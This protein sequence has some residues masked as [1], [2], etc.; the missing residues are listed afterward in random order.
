MLHRVDYGKELRHAPVVPQASERHGRPDGRMRVL[1]PIFSDSRGVPFDVSEISSLVG[2]QS[3]PRGCGLDGGAALHRKFQPRP[4]NSANPEDTEKTIVQIT[5]ET[6][7]VFTRELL[8]R[9]R[10]LVWGT[11]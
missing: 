5:R 4:S 8:E 9:S 10:H 6:P 2:N 11:D 1:P 3:L 7:T